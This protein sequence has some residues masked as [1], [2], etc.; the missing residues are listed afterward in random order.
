MNVLKIRLLG[1]L[2]LAAAVVI[3]AGDPLA[4]AADKKEEQKPSYGNKKDPTK[5]VKVV[6]TLAADAKLT[7]AQLAAHVDKM[8]AKKLK[9]EKIDA[10]ALCSDEEFVR[11]VYL[12]I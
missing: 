4:D 3:L 6:G 5:Q 1:G 11:R 8:V 2:A 7:S 10:S 9:E 12:D